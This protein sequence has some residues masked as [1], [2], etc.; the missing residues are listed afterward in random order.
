MVNKDGVG[1]AL[2]QDAKDKGRIGPN[3]VV[4]E[5]T[6]GNAEIGTAFARASTG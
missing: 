5:A 2:I 6:S 3:G 4:V 1:V